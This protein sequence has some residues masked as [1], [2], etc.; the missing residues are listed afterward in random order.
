V[1]TLQINKPRR[2]TTMDDRGRF[3]KMNE[4]EPLPP[5]LHPIR[6]QHFGCKLDSTWREGVFSPTLIEGM[7]NHFYCDS[8]IGN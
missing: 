6:C 3:V 1:S 7:H 5:Q 4:I 8:H 2:M